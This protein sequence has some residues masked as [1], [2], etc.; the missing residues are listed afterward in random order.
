MPRHVDLSIAGV[1]GETEGD[2][3]AVET[4]R[5]ALLAMRRSGSPYWQTRLAATRAAPDSP[6]ARMLGWGRR[7]RS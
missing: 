1:E 3:S 6:S 5:S 4:L 2:A 7:L